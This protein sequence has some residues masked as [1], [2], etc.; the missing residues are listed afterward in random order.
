[1]K[2]PPDCGSMSAKVVRLNK[3][4]YGLRQ[5]S[6]TFYKRLVSDLKRIGFEQSLSDPCVLRFMM[7]DEVMGMVA[8][9]VDDILYAGTK[10]LAKAVVEALGDSL[11]TKN[12]GDVKL[13]LGCAFIRDREAGTI[14]ISRLRFLKRVT[15]GVFSRDSIFVAPARSL[16]PLPTIT[17]P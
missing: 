5:A 6:R 12:W 15:S 13:F 3:S 2:L 1:M 9:H 14:E 8:I 4:L 7:G 11:P 10:S 17:G 16:L